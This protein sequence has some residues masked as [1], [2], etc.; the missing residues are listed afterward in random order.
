MG[1]PNVVND[2][3]DF[4]PTVDFSVSKDN[5]YVSVF[6]T[7]IR[8]LGGMLSAYDL[9][10]EPS[11][12]HLVKDQKKLQS[13][14]K[15]SESVANHLSFAFDTPS[16]IPSGNV[17]FGNR[18]HD[19]QSV[20]DLADIGTLVLEW[21]RLSDLTGNKTYA[22]L[23]QKAEKHLL[24]PMPKSDVP[25]SG[26]LGTNVSLE[27]GQFQDALGGW[28]AR[29]DSFYE[30]LMKV[31]VSSTP[32]AKRSSDNFFARCTSTTKAV[33]LN[34][35]TGKTFSKGFIQSPRGPRY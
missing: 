7:T 13:L 4:I 5:Q 14:L 10:H 23:S 25:W 32:Y 35:R 33:S 21:T 29:D 12:S 28:I 11:F 26:L 6:E 1:L 24:N 27:T 9:L 19:E 17:F 22:E 18:S 3:L 34:T 20:N 8:Y 30:Y 16:G 15:Q 2:I 31:N